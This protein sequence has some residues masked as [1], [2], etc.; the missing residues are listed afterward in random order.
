M[1]QC[2]DLT[3]RVTVILSWNISG[4]S[5]RSWLL[6]RFTVILIQFGGVVIGGTSE[7]YG[8]K[9]NFLVLSASCVLVALLMLGLVFMIC[10]SISSNFPS[11][12]IEILA[13]GSIVK[14]ETPTETQQNILSMLGIIQIVSCIVLPMGGLALSGILYYHI[15]LKQPISTLR[16]GISRIRNHDLDFSMPVHSDDELGQLCTALILCAKNF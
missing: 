9:E 4:K 16:N 15:K 14:M 12:G 6:V 2:G 11:G 10:N 8:I 3:A 7:K 1:K 13:D 5:G